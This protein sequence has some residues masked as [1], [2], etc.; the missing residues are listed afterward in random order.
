M[1]RIENCQKSK[2]SSTIR[3]KLKVPVP[4]QSKPDSFVS[5][6]SI[7]ESYDQLPKRFLRNMYAPRRRVVKPFS[8]GAPPLPCLATSWIPLPR[9][10]N[11]APPTPG[12]ELVDQVSDQFMRCQCQVCCPKIIA[13]TTEALRTTVENTASGYQYRMRAHWLLGHETEALQD[14]KSFNE[15]EPD[16][17]W[18]GNPIEGLILTK[19]GQYKQALLALGRAKWAHYPAEEIDDAIETCIQNLSAEDFADIRRRIPTVFTSD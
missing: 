2:S 12:D 1:F 3:P 9:E 10:A 16:P 6:P 4:K 11:E 17:S 7:I 19:R 5:Q 14:L 8:E 18:Y 15:V 13:M